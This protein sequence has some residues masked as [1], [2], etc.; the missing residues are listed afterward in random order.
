MSIVQE[1][2]T[3]LF[4]MG[5]ILLWFILVR[6]SIGALF[7]YYSNHLQEAIKYCES[8]NL[9]LIELNTPDSISMNRNPFKLKNRPPI[10]IGIW[11]RTTFIDHKVLICKSMDD[12]DVL[13]WRQTYASVFGKNHFK[14]SRE[15]EQL[16]ATA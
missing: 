5:F 13:I 9:I 2:F 4:A 8:Q 1:I 12:K 10:Y 15:A 11:P 16:K 3:S 7:F 14:Y 6:K